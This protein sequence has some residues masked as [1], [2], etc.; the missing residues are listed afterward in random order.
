MYNI[1][2]FLKNYYTMINVINLLRYDN[3]IFIYR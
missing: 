1:T 2:E 3:I